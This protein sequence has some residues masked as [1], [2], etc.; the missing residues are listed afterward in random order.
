MG[1][2]YLLRQAT[3]RSI[4][5]LIVRL[6]PGVELRDKRSLLEI[7][8]WTD[9]T[10]R[11]SRLALSFISSEQNLGT[12]SQKRTGYPVKRAGRDRGCNGNAISED[13]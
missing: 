11:C 6:S 7:V 10:S 12:D 5:V 4:L 1:S 2:A 9:K 8:S 3:G 13:L